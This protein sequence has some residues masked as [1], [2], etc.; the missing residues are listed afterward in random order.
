MEPSRKTPSEVSLVA[1]P[2][3]S[4]TQALDRAVQLT[5]MVV[6]ADAPVSFADLQAATGLAKSTTSR[7]LAALERGNLLERE[8]NGGYVAGSLF[9]LYA[10]RHDPWDQLVRLAR[11][12]MERI[13]RD[14]QESV[15][16][17]VLRGDRVVQ[18]A[19]VDSQYL[20][21]HPR[22]DPGRRPGP[23]LLPRQD[24]PGLGRPLPRGH[25][26]GAGHA[27]HPDHGGRARARRR[28]DPQ[29]GYAVTVDELEEGLTGVAVPVRGTRGDVVAALGI[30]GPTSRLDGR[31]E[32]LGRNL[33]TRASEIAA[34]LHGSTTRLTKEG[35]A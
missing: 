31:I 34:V 6:E 15:H 32:E 26:S 3:G 21:G 30:S 25:G 12:T 11:P 28:D 13:G 10:A 2:A 8:E 33:I 18:V 23:H 19:Q 7:L 35:V 27:A 9:W 24:L 20:L 17:S 29:R 14:T 1:E 5:S 22:L 16:L 4:G